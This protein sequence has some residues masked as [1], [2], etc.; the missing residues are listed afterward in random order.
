MKIVSFGMVA[1][2]IVA[3]ILLVMLAGLIIVLILLY[4]KRYQQHTKIMTELKQSYEHELLK[5]Q[6]EIQEETL[7]YIRQEIL[8]NIGQVLSLAKLHLNTLPEK[9]QD[10]NRAA[11][12]NSKQLVGK[13]INDLRNLSKNLNPE[14]INELGLETNIKHELKMLEK[15]QKYSASLQVKGSVYPISGQT[16]TIFFRIVQEALHNII[17]HA[18]ANLIEVVMDYEPKEFSILIK[19]NGIG[20]NSNISSTNTNLNVGLKNIQYRSRLIGAA[21]LISP[22]VGGGTNIK[23]SLPK[24]KI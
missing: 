1:P 17:K 2:T 5:S 23:I 3:S 15:T 19:D 10:G 22:V 6:L 12:D 20:F 4:R 9:P 7:K 8:D 14:K 18:K 13:A 24:E 16:Q 21:F 11:I